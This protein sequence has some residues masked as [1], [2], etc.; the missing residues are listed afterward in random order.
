MTLAQRL[1]RSDDVIARGWNRGTGMASPHNFR[2]YSPVFVRVAIQRA[3]TT[4][5]FDAGPT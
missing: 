3:T 1:S 5:L 2:F 4:S